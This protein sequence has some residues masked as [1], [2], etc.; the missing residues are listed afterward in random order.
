LFQLERTW[1]RTP[2]YKA[3]M[4]KKRK[5][6]RFN[7]PMNNFDFYSR[8]SNGSFGS[9]TQRLMPPATSPGP[10]EYEVYGSTDGVAGV[11]SYPYGHPDIPLP[12]P[13]IDLDA[14]DAQARFKSLSDIKDQKVN[15][16]QAFA[17]RGQTVRLIGETIN[18]LN[19]S[20]VSLKR[21]N[22]GAAAKA[23]GVDPGA[24]RIRK[25]KKSWSEDQS[26][27]LA[28]GWLELQYGWRPLLSDIY[29]S[30][31]TLAQQN[32]REVR[33]ISKT[34]VTRIVNTKTVIPPYG[35]RPS[36]TYHIERK[37]TIKYVIYFSTPASNHSLTQIG[38]TNPL[39]IAWELTP[40]SFVAD[41]FLPLGNYI[42]SLDAA[43]GLDFEKGCCTTF[44]K[45]TLTG[46]SRSGPAE[47]GIEWLGEATTDTVEVRCKRR[48]FSAFP[49]ASLPR[50]KN[51]FST[52]HVLNAIALLRT[53][54]RVR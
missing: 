32:V 26:K 49:S 36:A 2:G 44:E 19:T 35:G 54:L 48:A 29:G 22:F 41:W 52:V 1:V 20:I 46:R 12:M 40:W 4:K 16:V 24:R 28:N 3:L 17:E 43:S 11:A 25:Y 5:R 51:P 6:D 7:L 15:I 21:G 53:N 50:F 42:S 38:L 33:N 9:I 47:P 8:I 37:V 18:R 23:L 34:R 14:L 27:A 30:A 45:L 31:E 10:L 13:P 39:L